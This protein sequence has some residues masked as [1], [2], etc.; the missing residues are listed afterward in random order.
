MAD[1]AILIN[2]FEVLAADADAF[3]AAWEKARDHLRSQPGY[4]DTVL[5]QAITPDAEF[6]FVNI[7]LADG[8][9]LHRRR[10]KPWF[11]RVSRRPGPLPAASRLTC[12]KCH[13][14]ARWEE[15]WLRAR[16]PPFRAARRSSRERGC[17]AAECR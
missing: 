15:R 17:A 1:S 4:L 8:R 2:A 7:A 9:G 10:A 14:T 3:V 11:R 6:Q 12:G 5:H 13:H 16:E